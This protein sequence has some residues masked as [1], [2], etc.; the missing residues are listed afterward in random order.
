LRK[1]TKLKPRFPLSRIPDIAER[2]S[3][4]FEAKVEALVPIVRRQGYLTRDQLT[5]L[6]RWKSPRSA[7]HAIKN[8]RKFVEEITRFAF[9][10]ADERAR[11]ES[12]T[13]LNAVEY[14]TASTILHWFHSDPYPIVDFRA[15]WSLRLSETPPYSFA[16]WQS[17]V[18][19]W[20]VLLRQGQESCAPTVVTPRLFDKALWSYSDEHQ[21]PNEA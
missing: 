17:Y 3:Y 6:C 10:A 19:G 1:N 12:L 4:A 5:T 8:S 11:I 16:F 18:S 2:Y 13:L 14:P 20:R 9:S 15:L 21:P 7:G